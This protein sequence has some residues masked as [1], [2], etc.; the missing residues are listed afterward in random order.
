MGVNV[1]CRHTRLLLATA[2]PG[3]SAHALPV[4]YWTS[5]FTS[6]YSVNV[7]VG[8]G[9][10]GADQLSCTLKTSISPMTSV[11][12]K[13]TSSQSGGAFQMLLLHPPPFPQFNP[14]RFPV[15]A[16]EGE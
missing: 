14:A 5:K 12:A 1:N 6:P 4:Q 3:T 2:P 10:L 13:S 9:V 15:I 7:I 11:A 8:V 16:L